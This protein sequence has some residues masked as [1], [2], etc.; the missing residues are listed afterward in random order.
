MNELV[1]I[2]TPCFNSGNTIE[3]TILSVLNQTYDNIEYIIID[4]QSQD[5]TL[6]IINKYMEHFGERIKVVSEPDGGI[7]DAMNKGILLAKGS[8]IGIVNSDDY[9]E[10]STVELAVKKLSGDPYQVIYGL[11]RCLNK[12]KEASVVMYNHEFINERMITHPTCFI[13]KRTYEDFGLYDCKYK[14]SADY[15]LMLRLN[16]TG[17]VVFHSIYEIM[18]N[19]EVGGISSTDLAVRETA[20]LRLSYGI[21]SKTRFVRVMLKSYLHELYLKIKK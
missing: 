1:S 2:I 7:Y 15:E 6:N 13:T 17:K 10:T 16:K 9:Y 12:G 4:G 21:I 20:R 3:K 14:S 8:L 19:F 18:S 11:L 5:N